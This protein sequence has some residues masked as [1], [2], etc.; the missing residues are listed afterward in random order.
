MTKDYLLGIRNKASS[1]KANTLII[2]LQPQ[3]LSYT[4]LLIH[5]I[6]RSPVSGHNFSN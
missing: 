1:L 4:F 5:L 3:V 2:R 6:L